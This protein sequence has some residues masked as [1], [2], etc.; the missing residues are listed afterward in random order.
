MKIL[1]FALLLSQKITLRFSIIRNWYT[2][3][4]SINKFVLSNIRNF[5]WQFDSWS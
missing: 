3:A 2:V 4:T 5:Q 1:L